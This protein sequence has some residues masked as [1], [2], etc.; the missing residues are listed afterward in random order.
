MGE[1]EEHAFRL[2]LENTLLA[3]VLMVALLLS[4]GAAW[5]PVGKRFK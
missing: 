1:E 5:G 4:G 3:L 2:R